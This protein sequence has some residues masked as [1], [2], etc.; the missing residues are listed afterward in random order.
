MGLSL[1]II[2]GYHI[3]VKTPLSRQPFILFISLTITALFFIVG[4]ID[5]LLSIWT[6][7]VP[8]IQKTGCGLYLMA[9]SITSLLAI[10]AFTMKMIFMIVSQMGALAQRSFLLGHCIT[11]DFAV[12]V[13]LNVGDWL[14]ACVCVERALTI[15]Q[16]IGFNPARSKQISKVVTGLVYLVVMISTLHEPLHRQLVDDPDEGRT[17]CVT[18]YSSLWSVIN[19][20]AV[21]V[22][23]V[24]PFIINIVSALLIIVMGAR[25]R[26]AVQQH[27]TL[28]QHLRAQFQQHKKLLISP[29]ILIVL[30]T[31][32]LIIAFASG[33]MT[34]ARE[35]WLFLAGYLLAF[36]PPI[37]TFAVFVLPSEVYKAEFLRLVRTAR[38]KARRLFH[39]N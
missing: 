4:L 24:A 9:T 20:V 29:C 1:D 33:C 12:R 5:A 26:S 14:R 25:R 32:R 2:L 13:L 18:G 6:F 35:S 31:P 23:F 37:L 16:G 27:L 17:W 11:M 38:V 8:M 28:R 10:A 21:S 3:Q 7:R 34:S 36:I 22:H 39:G 30:T 15:G 19:A